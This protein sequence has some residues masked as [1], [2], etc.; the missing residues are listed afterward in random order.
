MRGRHFDS[1]ENGELRAKIDKAKRQ[2]PLPDLMSLLGLGEHAKKSARCLWHDDQRPSFSV[3]K[4][5]DGFW[6]YKC[7]V[8]DMQGGDEIAFLV[9]HFDIS[10]R[11]AIKRYLDMAGFPPG[12]SPKSREYPEPR[13]FPAFPG[14]PKFP[15][16]PVS[17]VSN[18]QGLDGE[19]EKALKALAARNASTAQNSARKRRFQLVRDLRALEKGISRELEIAELM[20]AFDEW[21]RLSERFF[22]PTKTREDYL[23]MFLAELGKVRVPTG[24]GATLDKAL[25]AVSKLSAFELPVVPGYLGAP[26]SWR[27]LTALHREL[28]CQSA[29]GTYFLSYRDAAKAYDGLSHQSAHTVTLAL[30]QL[31]VIKIVGKGKPGLNS[32]K[33]AEFRY[34]LPQTENGPGEDD[35]GLQI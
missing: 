23:A 1:T 24:E 33:A 17:P 22:D 18:G 8:C 15:V 29:N 11:E 4:G 26:E 6:H 20:I 14:C 19:R 16:Y 3:F 35:D 13:K 5:D 2:L 21:H 30:A 7:F 25:E 9:K 28:S 32:G 31:G 27:R 12:R 34:L 10:Q